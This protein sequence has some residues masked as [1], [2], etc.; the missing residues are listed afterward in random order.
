MTIEERKNYV[1]KIL[2]DIQ[3]LFECSPKESEELLVEMGKSIYKKNLKE[4][5]KTNPFLN[6]E[7]C[8]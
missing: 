7:Y 5:V 8:K 1:D 6:G 3:Q 4:F 2:I